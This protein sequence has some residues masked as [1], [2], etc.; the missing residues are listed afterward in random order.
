MKS[1]TYFQP[2]EIRFGRGRLDEVGEAVA[3]FGKRCL[4]VTGSVFPTVD[5]VFDRVRSS[6]QKA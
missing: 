6:L 1:F 3:R 5:S 4:I 2:T